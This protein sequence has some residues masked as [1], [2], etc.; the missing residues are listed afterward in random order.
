MNIRIAGRSSQERA[1]T[2]LP[3]ALSLSPCDIF[4]FA[5]ASFPLISSGMERENILGNLRDDLTW[6]DGM[7]W[8][9]IGM[10]V[11]TCSFLLPRLCIYQPWW[12]GLFSL[13]PPTILGYRFGLSLVRSDLILL[14]LGSLRSSVFRRT[15]SVFED[16]GWI[17][18]LGLFGQGLDRSALLGL[19]VDS[20]QSY[21]P[22]IS[23]ICHTCGF[24]TGLMRCRGSVGDVE[25]LWH[26][27][28]VFRDLHQ[29]IWD[30][31]CHLAYA[32]S[33][34]QNFREHELLWWVGARQEVEGVLQLG[35]GG[36]HQGWSL[37]DSRESV[38]SEGK[39]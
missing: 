14:V 32:K 9:G 5:I 4:P 6:V 17:C 30:L 26:E 20:L 36:L 10:V 11:Y 33:V 7:V 16:V 38:E 1:I 39:S 19:G 34:V 12:C 35:C 13:T 22:R 31:C 15:T 21:G 24:G 25:E 37:S 23:W 3:R 29:G 18:G 27:C 2:T 8:Y 28:S